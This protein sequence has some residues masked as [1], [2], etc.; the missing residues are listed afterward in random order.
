MNQQ[1]DKSGRLIIIAA[2]SGAGKSS[3]VRELCNSDPQLIASVSH[4]TRP[5]RSGEREGIHYFFV[6][7]DSFKGM[8]EQR[9]FL[10]HARVYGYDY[11]TAKDWVVDKL[12]QGCDVILEID[13]QGAAQVRCL[14]PDSASI[15]ILP[16]SI[17]AL[18]ER[19]R[20]RGEAVAVI[21]KRMQAVDRELDH[22]RVCDFAVINDDF[23]QALSELREHIDKIRAEQPVTE[24]NI[25]PLIEKLKSNQSLI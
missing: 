21:E 22:H 1:T 7:N 8:V 25:A 23:A 4:T 2:P 5:K 16:P 15:F 17:A 14:M 6:N 9:R 12:H 19:L 24:Q 18:E 3:L 10:E 11:G 20:K 13:W